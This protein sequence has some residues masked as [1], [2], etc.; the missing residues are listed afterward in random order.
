MS[1][2]ST[3]VSSD[4]EI[5]LSGFVS[6][7][8]KTAGCL[9]AILVILVCARPLRAQ[10]QPIQYYYDDPGRLVRVVDQSGNVVTFSDDV[11]GR[12]LGSKHRSAVGFTAMQDTANLE[13]VGGGV[14]EKE[15]V[16]AECG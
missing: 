1:R 16:V 6:S 14:D 13:G 5:L 4:S 2:A 12:T 7:L 8:T 3:S 10:S 11:V 15:P 9:T